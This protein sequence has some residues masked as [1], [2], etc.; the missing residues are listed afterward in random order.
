MFN[1]TTQYV[2]D[3]EEEQ[4]NGNLNV[5]RSKANI[6]VDYPNDGRILDALTMLILESY[7]PEMPKTIEACR[8]NLVSAVGDAEEDP[9]HVLL[10]VIFKVD[11]GETEWNLTKSEINE[12]L[13]V[14]KAVKSNKTPIAN[15]KP[16]KITR[17]LTNR[18][19][20]EEKNVSRMVNGKKWRGRGLRC[21]QVREEFI[22]TAQ[23]Q[24]HAV[25]E[26]CNEQL[27]AMHAKGAV[28]AG[29]LQG[30]D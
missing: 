10:E 21:I 17:E 27:K 25:P 16:L 24:G 26:V 28:P 30:N 3:L 20:I 12:V 13:K 8:S 18:G 1:L 6:K 19:A 22:Q 2:Q 4:R 5:R 11:P 7:M 29:C 9:K 23:D 14:Y 15:M